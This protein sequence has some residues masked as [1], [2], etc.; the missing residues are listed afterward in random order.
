MYLLFFIYLLTLLGFSSTAV[1]PEADHAGKALAVRQTSTSTTATST[2]P[3]DSQCTNGPFTRLC[4]GNG[5]SA[6]TD[7]DV[8]WPNTGIIR[9]YQLTITNTTM[10]PDG[11]PRLVMAVNG[12]YPGP[13][14][15]ADWGD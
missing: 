10:A 6:S 9:S 7:Y 1:L 15:I 5:F 12:Q 14:I 8:S 4:W 3:L 11:H 13:T 2:S